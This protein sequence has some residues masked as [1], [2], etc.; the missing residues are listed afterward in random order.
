MLVKILNLMDRTRT[1]ESH[2]YEVFATNRDSTEATSA[3][4]GALQCQQLCK[5]AISSHRYMAEWPNLECAYAEVTL[6]PLSLSG[7]CQTTCTWLLII[8]LTTRSKP[9]RLRCTVARPPS[10]QGSKPPQKTHS[11]GLQRL[12]WLSWTTSKFLHDSLLSQR[13]RPFSRE[14]E[15]MWDTF[16]FGLSLSKSP[17]LSL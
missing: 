7:S 6:F 17:I 10:E 8:A 9:T 4:S 12:G 11:V 16:S 15:R 3:V 13:H 14:L 2:V 1:I 5:A